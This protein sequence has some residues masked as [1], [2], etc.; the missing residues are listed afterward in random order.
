MK[1]INVKKILAV[2]NVT[3]AVNNCEDLDICKCN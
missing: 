2:T 1:E 3:Y